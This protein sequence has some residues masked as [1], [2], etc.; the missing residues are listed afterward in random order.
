MNWLNTLY[1][2]KIL[3]PIE[4]KRVVPRKA[5]IK[6][7]KPCTVSLSN[8][9]ITICGHTLYLLWHGYVGD[10]VLATSPKTERF[11]QGGLI[12][13]FL[14]PLTGFYNQIACFHKHFFYALVFG[15]FQCFK[16]VC[17]V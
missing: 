5:V 17:G 9:F 6:S 4:G 11:S 14:L 1:R 2:P 12:P 3:L 10:F 8:S 16:Q 13:R 7:Q 15:I